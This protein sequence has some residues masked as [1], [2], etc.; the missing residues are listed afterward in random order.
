MTQTRNPC[1]AYSEA[2]L[3]AVYDPLNPPGEDHR[4]YLELAGTLP[5]AVLDIGCGTGRLAV[6][7]ARRGHRVTGAD[8]SPGMLDIARRRTGGEQVAWVEA[9]AAGLALTQRFDLIV[10]MGHAFQVLLVDADVR[11]ALA[12]LRRHLAPGGR[13]AFETRNPLVREWEDWIPER[14][15]ET[16]EV[17]GEGPVEASF[18][19][20]QAEGELVT[21]QTRFRFPDGEVVAVPHTLRFM[22]KARLAQLL[23]EAGLTDVTWYG[24]W[25][26][27]PFAA[28]APEII[29]IAG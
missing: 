27:S 5:L 11:A 4:F 3:A 10:M 12:N 1:A 18:D 20:L 8:P 17:P 29:V 6:D 15:R 21:F 19:I 24:Y 22:S 28:T 14:S 2:R 25:D 23:A 26:R 9:G 13:L 16:I 7:L